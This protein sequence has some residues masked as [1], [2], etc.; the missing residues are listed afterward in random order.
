MNIKITPFHEK[1]ITETLNMIQ[2]EATDLIIH[3]Y[4]HLESLCKDV[5]KRLS[6]IPKDKLSK[7]LEGTQF[8]YDFRFFDVIKFHHLIGTHVTCLYKHGTW[9]LI[10]VHRDVVK[11]GCYSYPYGLE[12]SEKAKEAI[13]EQYE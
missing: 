8:T 10:D 9:R 5:E 11:Q 2:G 3:G 6:I 12:L 13:L 1:K 4:S 7:V